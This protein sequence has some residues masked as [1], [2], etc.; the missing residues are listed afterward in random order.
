[1]ARKWLQPL[2]EGALDW[3]TDDDVQLLFDLALHT[4]E[5]VPDDA[6]SLEPSANE[7][8]GFVLYL[9]ELRFESASLA[10]TVLNAF[11]A[12]NESHRSWALGRL[13]LL[14]GYDDDV[15]VSIKYIGQATMAT[16]EQRQQQDDD[17]MWTLWM[18][19]LA[20]AQSLG[21]SVI[22]RQFRNASQAGVT[23]IDLRGDMQLSDVELGAIALAGPLALANSAAGGLW[24]R[25]KST[26]MLDVIIDNVNKEVIKIWEAAP[27]GAREETAPDGLLDVMRIQVISLFMIAAR[28]FA[29]KHPNAPTASP[30]R[31][32]EL[33]RNALPRRLERDGSLAGL[34]CQKDIT[35][36]D[37]RAPEEPFF[38]PRAGPG[39]RFALWLWSMAYR[40]A[41]GV[42]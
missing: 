13:D 22:V 26:A 15:P 37:I 39:P 19:L 7:P 31:A 40:H 5:P 42:T 36:E 4:L 17:G 12:R 18:D 2:T 1:M 6:P 33:A 41:P 14:S 29:N 25:F 38:T 23:Q 27:E 11:A 8:S 3:T 9:R 20:L 24:P 28:C 16:A 10:R 30:V 35:A 21:A 32:A 34:W